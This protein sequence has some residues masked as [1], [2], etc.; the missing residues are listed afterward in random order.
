MSALIHIK[1]L[2]LQNTPEGPLRTAVMGLINAIDSD[3][4]EYGYIQ[5]SDV[6]DAIVILDKVLVESAE[7]ADLD[8]TIE[9]EV[10]EDDSTI[11]EEDVTD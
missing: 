5:S 7:D 9:A 8:A 2:V 1:S 11:N 4:D 3:L 10:I 6:D